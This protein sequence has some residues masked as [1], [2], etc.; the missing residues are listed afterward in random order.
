MSRAP[1]DTPTEATAENGEV[2]LDG[3][4]GLAT[5]MTP[6]AARKSAAAIN[7]AADEAAGQVAGQVAG[8][9]AA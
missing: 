7:A 5:S 4:D 2:L 1:H 8:N 9:T 6:E 3:P